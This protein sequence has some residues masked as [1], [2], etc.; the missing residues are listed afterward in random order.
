MVCLVQNNDRQRMKARITDAVATV[1]L[2]ML[3]TTGQKRNILWIFVVPLGVTTLKPVGLRSLKVFLC[4]VS[5]RTSLSEHMTRYCFFFWIITAL[6]S[7]MKDVQCSDSA[8]TVLI[9]NLYL[10]I[11]Y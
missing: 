8:A 4:N 10:F 5:Y 9:K 2:N 11:A 3:K 7:C 1:T 6:M